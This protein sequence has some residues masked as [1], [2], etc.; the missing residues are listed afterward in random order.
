ML[1]RGKERGISD[2]VTKL[3]R[4]MIPRT[5]KMGI[6]C[7]A[8]AGLVLASCSSSSSSVSSQ[9]KSIAKMPTSIKAG[10]VS[11]DDPN[12]AGVKTGEFQA[13]EGVPINWS[14]FQDAT[15]I[16]TALTSSSVDI[17]MLGSPAVAIDI[18]DGIPL[19]VIWVAEGV[20]KNEALAVQP[21]INSISDLKGKTI[22]TVF[23]STSQFTLLAALEDA[24]VPSSSVNIINLEPPEIAAAYDTGKIAGGYIWNP[25]LSEMLAHG[26]HELIDTAEL[27][28]RGQGTY[29]LIVAR[30]PFVK[31]YPKAIT[32]WDSAEISLLH[33]YDRNP[34]SLA[35]PLG[36]LLSQSST[37]VRKLMTYYQYF[38]LSGEK[39]LL[40]SAGSVGSLAQ[41]LEG[42]AKFAFKLK[43]IST[44]PPLSVYQGALAGTLLP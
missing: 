29:D 8:V 31:Q 43:L 3:K 4:G 40:G 7:L 15:E 44:V 41:V 36:V 33:Q 42:E 28:K 30:S 16:T 32:R 5:T 18:A 24:H 27:A 26:A 17:S 34:G 23:G 19:K 14:E 20:G 10:W 2:E 35:T 6:V 12:D 37:S 25:S 22:A 1:S 38:D 21:G 39:Q 9:V 13:K 11:V